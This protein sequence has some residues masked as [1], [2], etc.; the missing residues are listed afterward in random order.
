MCVCVCVCVRVLTDRFSNMICM[1]SFMRGVKSF[2]SARHKSPTT[3]TVVMHTCGSRREEGRE[4]GEERGERGREAE[5]GR[6]EERREGR[7]GEGRSGKRRGDK[8]K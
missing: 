1:T 4:G 6:G 2:S 8:R 7:K 5:K 3:P